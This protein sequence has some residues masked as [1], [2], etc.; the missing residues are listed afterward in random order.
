[1]ITLSTE[2]LIR[3][4]TFTERSAKLNC[5]NRALVLVLL[6]FSFKVSA[7]DSSQWTYGCSHFLYGGCIRVLSTMT[8]TSESPADYSI[9]R[10]QASG[11]NVLSIYEGDAAKEIPHESA[12]MVIKGKGG[13]ISAFRQVQGVSVRYDVFV[14]KESSS[15]ASIHLVGEASNVSERAQLASALASF[16]ICQFNDGRRYQRLECPKQSDIGEALSEWVMGEEN[17]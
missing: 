12:S 4:L 9:H 11:R 13:V 10:I 3:I 1:M 6:L 16:R 14:R 15:A 8:V 2:S 5:V 17:S 7:Q